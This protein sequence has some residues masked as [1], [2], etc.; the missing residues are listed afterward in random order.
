ME[1]ARALLRAVS[2]RVEGK[3]AVEVGNGECRSKDNSPVGTVDL[4]SARRESRLR[5]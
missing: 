3:T 2:N 4:T 1:A 5:P